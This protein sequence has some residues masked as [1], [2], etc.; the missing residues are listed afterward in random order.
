MEIAKMC[1][2]LK[3]LR[4]EKGLTQEQAAEQLFVTPKTLSRW[5]TGRTI[6]DLE[7]V[8]RLADFYEVDIKDLLSGERAPESETPE[9]EEGSYLKYSSRVV[10]KGDRSTPLK[11]A[12][13]RLYYEF[14]EE[15]AA[16]FGVTR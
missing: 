3:E 4:K 10:P 13:D 2:F 7:T 1:L 12:R 14:M 6:P 15:H 9:G 5:E 8:L 16:E 11:R